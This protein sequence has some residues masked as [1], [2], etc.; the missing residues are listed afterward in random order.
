MIRKLQNVLFLAELGYVLIALAG[1]HQVYWVSPSG[2]ATSDCTNANPCTLQ[3]A[4][5]KSMTDRAPSEIILLS[6]TYNISTTAIYEVDNGD[7]DLT[8]RGDDPNNRPILN[9]V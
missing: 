1:A 4:L 9:A 5:T 3:K 8:I 2:D 6:G 7:S